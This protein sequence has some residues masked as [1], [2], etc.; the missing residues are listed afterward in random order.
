M[1][2]F[3]IPKSPYPND[4][5]QN[6]QQSNSRD[7]NGQYQRCFIVWL[8]SGYGT[9][10]KM[11]MFYFWVLTLAIR[12]YIDFAV[13]LMK[14]ML[15]MTSQPLL[16]PKTDVLLSVVERY[17]LILVGS[18]ITCLS[19]DK[20]NGSKEGVLKNKSYAINLTLC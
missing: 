20:S 12:L 10:K 2:H 5:N 6:Y 18:G 15:P 3:F 1:K 19:F 9:Y 4:S 7:N 11:S 16:V 14:V 13:T 17:V 8:F